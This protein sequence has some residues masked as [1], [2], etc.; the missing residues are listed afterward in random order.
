VSNT[1]IKNLKSLHKIADGEESNNELME[2]LQH[3]LGCV[4]DNAETLA[5]VAE[6]DL[7]LCWA[8]ATRDAWS[9]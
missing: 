6:C 7:K 3:K 9:K 5:D 1:L 8:K 2:I 4:S